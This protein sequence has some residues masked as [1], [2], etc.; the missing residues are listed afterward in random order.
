MGLFDEIRFKAKL[1]IVGA[2]ALT[3]QTKDTPSQFMDSYE[4]REDGTLWHEVYDVED[5]SDTNADG[6]LRIRGMM[7]RTNK[8]WEP[9][10]MTGEIRFYTGDKGWWIE[11]SSYFRDLYRLLPIDL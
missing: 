9:C 4:V 6:F 2:E 3:Y 1:P 5:R 8:H 10:G 11:F 7:T